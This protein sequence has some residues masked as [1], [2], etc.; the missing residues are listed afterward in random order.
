MDAETAWIEDRGEGLADSIKKSTN[1]W[2][3]GWAISESCKT[4]VNQWD[5]YRGQASCLTR[6]SG[7]HHD[8]FL[9]PFESHPYG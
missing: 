3:P 7:F 5:K 8:L 6:Q 1:D 9:H 2:G 4:K